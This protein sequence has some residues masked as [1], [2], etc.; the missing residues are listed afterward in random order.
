[1]SFDGSAKTEKYGWYGSCSWILWQ[2]PGWTIVIAAS[3]FLESTTVNVAEYP[4]MNNGVA[5]ALDNGVE[6]LVIVGDSRP[7]IQQSIGVIACKKDLLMAKLNHHRELTRLISVRYLQVVRE[8]NAAADSLASEAL[9]SRT[10][11][12]VSAEERLSE[13]AELNRILKVIYGQQASSPTHEISSVDMIRSQVRY[14]VRDTPQDIDPLKVQ[15]E[16]RKRI[17]V[18]QNEELRWYNLKAVLRGDEAKLSYKAARDTWKISEK[19]VLSE[20]GILFY[21]RT[22][23]RRGRQHGNTTGRTND[24]DPRSATELP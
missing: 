13:L 11:K 4:G 7:A 17:A 18:A 23:Q 15:H 21:E 14:T 9:E 19:F 16:R 24:V 3:A 1:M 6:D 12:V 8:Y 20:D 10:S 5:A 2:L 22:N